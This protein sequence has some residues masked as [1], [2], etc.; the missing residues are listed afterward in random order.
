MSTHSGLGS[1]GQALT[2]RGGG[3]GQKERAGFDSGSCERERAA[4][5]ERG[6]GSYAGTGIRWRPPPPSGCPAR[7]VIPVFAF[8]AL[9]P[10]DREGTARKERW[11]PEGIR[12]SPQRGRRCRWGAGAPLRGRPGAGLWVR[13]GDGSA[14]APGSVGERVWVVEMG[15]ELRLRSM[16]LSP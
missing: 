7:R 13:A 4:D 1:T 8:R 2:L 6:G 14:Q 15:R 12:A 16:P 3:G 5:A 10:I 11:K 9:Q